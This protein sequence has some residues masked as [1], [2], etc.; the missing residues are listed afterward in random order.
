MKSQDN[1]MITVLTMIISALENEWYLIDWSAM[2]AV[3][4]KKKQNIE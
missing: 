4:K 1:E 3:R 2:C